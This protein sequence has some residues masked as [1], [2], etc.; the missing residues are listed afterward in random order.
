MFNR[1]IHSL[2]VSVGNTTAELTFACGIQLYT[3]PRR[4]AVSV[5]FENWPFVILIR[6][7]YC[8]CVLFDTSKLFFLSK[9]MCYL[10]GILYSLKPQDSFGEFDNLFSWSSESTG[11]HIKHH[12]TFL[13]LFLM[14]HI[15]ICN[16]AQVLANYHYVQKTYGKLFG[17]TPIFF[18]CFGVLVISW[19]WKRFGANC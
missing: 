5:I 19:K 18:L 13:Q 12:Q 2:S 7:E 10:K 4:R 17:G 6:H 11:N 9:I 8:I 14:T 15:V 1:A 16:V 3:E